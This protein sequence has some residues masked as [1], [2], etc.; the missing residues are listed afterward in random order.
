MK[1]SRWIGAL[2]ACVGGLIFA[3][4]SL[5]EAQQPARQPTRRVD[6]DTQPGQPGR[7]E[8]SVPLSKQKRIR[9]VQGGPETG[10]LEIDPQSGKFEPRRQ[11]VL[12]AP[13]RL[14]PRPT[15]RWRLGLRTDNA[16]KGLLI[17]EVTRNS[18][19]Y[20]FGIEEGDYLLDVAG[21]PVGFYG[22]AYYPLADTLNQV[23][24]R[25]GWV[26]LLIWNKRT[27]AE[28]AMWVQAEP[29]LAVGPR[30]ESQN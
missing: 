18:P 26:N 30:R 10:G 4:C 5:S 11:V 15:A 6:N 2:L 9:I 25:N 17:T 28:E 3:N 29:R 24:P 27:N 16:P 22:G 1:T 13:R 7:V 19:A 14:P 21:Y 23:T 20:K 8:I 12:A